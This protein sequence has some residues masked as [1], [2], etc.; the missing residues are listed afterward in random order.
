MNHLQNAINNRAAMN[1]DRSAG[2]VGASFASK[3]SNRFSTISHKN[4][5][6][7]T[8]SVVKTQNQ[9][10]SSGSHNESNSKT[11]EKSATTE[12]SS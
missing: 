12:Q 6:P 3:G 8:S 1:N 4:D 10:S 5:R 9:S 11:I 2:A 7:Q